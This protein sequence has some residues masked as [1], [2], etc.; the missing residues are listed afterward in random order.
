M[1]RGLGLLVLVKKFKLRYHNR[2]LEG[3]LQGI[4]K[5]SFKGF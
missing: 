2:V 4:Y 5:G 1:F 3:F